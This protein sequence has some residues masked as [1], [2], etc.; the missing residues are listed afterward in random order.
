MGIAPLQYKYDRC[1]MEIRVGGVYPDLA[2][3]K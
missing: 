2:F 3:Y 1:A